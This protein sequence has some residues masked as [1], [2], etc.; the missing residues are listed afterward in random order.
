M[1][2]VT[3]GELRRMKHNNRKDM[4]GKHDKPSTPFIFRSVVKNGNSKSLN[5]SDLL[6]EWQQVRITV[7][8]DSDKAITLLIEDVMGL[9]V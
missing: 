1:R 4:R 3:L 9:K 5:L 7:L 2:L 6:K 8:E